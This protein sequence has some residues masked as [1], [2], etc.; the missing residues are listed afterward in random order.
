MP[1]D[2]RV[3]SWLS[4]RGRLRVGLPLLWSRTW[5]ISTLY[6]FVFSVVASALLE[7]ERGAPESHFNTIGDS[8]WFCI[9]TLATVGYGDLYPVTPW[10]RFVTACFILFTLTTI[11]FLLAAINEAV[12]EIKRM[13]ENGLL[14]TEFKGHV[15]VY[16]F[17]PV[18]QVAVQEL[19]GAERQV[20]WMCEHAD[21]LPVARRMGPRE[22]L[23]LTWG[24]LSQP[25][26]KDRLNGNEAA[27]AIIATNDDSRDRKSVV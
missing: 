23:Y 1:Y 20:A 17:G 16:G 22:K 13:E 14:G 8:L 7:L 18:A 2:A 21:E 12:L 5:R 19:L 10:G 24:E 4:K 11:G 3:Q 6:V 27:T 15:V 26:L 25:L 9:V